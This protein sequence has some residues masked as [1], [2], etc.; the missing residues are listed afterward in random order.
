M[1]K[2]SRAAYKNHVLNVIL[3][4]LPGSLAPQPRDLYERDTPHGRSARAATAGRP[5][6]L[7]HP[8][9]CPSAHASAG[10]EIL[11]PRLHF[12]G[13]R[14]SL[15]PASFCLAVKKRDPAQFSDGAKSKPHCCLQTP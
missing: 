8:T 7:A 5:P 14:T 12:S 10:P 1:I 13:S 4:L 15:P 9:L 11:L 3:K 6:R 2:I